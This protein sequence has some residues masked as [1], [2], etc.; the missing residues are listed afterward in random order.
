MPL[1][2]QKQNR[3]WKSGKNYK[4][5]ER[6]NKYMEGLEMGQKHSLARA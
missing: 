4:Y 2:K 1:K 3:N 5:M 6:V